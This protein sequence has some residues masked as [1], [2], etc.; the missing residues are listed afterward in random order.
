[1]TH[2]HPTPEQ[3]LMTT[4]HLL[5]R[6]GVIDFNGH[7][8][9]RLD[10][11]RFLIN[12]ADSIR[13]ALTPDD[14]VTVNADGSVDSDQPRPPN[15]LALHLAVY[16]ARP[17]VN[18]VVHGHPE[19]STLLTS[20][21]RPYQVVFPQGAVPGDIPVFDSPRSISNVET[22]EA[23]A[24]ILGD[25]KAALMKAHG[26]VV[27]AD[28]LL[29]AAV[30]AIY[31]EMNAERQ[32]RCEP[33]GGAYVFSDPE[34]EGSRKGLSKRALYEKCWGFYRAKYGL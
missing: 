27:V 13:C 2:E 25:G 1:M 34:I 10:D 30:L 20:A 19:W 17:D 7:A 8:S 31:L 6:Y 3:T 5:E 14:L 4:V 16:K 33:L 23:V 9:L 32:V 21:G 11:G 29:E 22:A 15:E 26:C 28:D 24:R 12:S 18:A